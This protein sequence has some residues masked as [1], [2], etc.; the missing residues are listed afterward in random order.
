[1]AQE[2]KR[3]AVGVDKSEIVLSKPLIGGSGFP[4]QHTSVVPTVTETFTWTFTDPVRLNGCDLNILSN[5]NC[6]NF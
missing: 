5:D 1:M 3:W 4:Y 2:K 6:L